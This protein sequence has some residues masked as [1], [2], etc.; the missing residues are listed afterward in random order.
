MTVRHGSG[1]ILTRIRK[2]L[3][4]SI[5]AATAEHRQKF[6]HDDY[7]AANIALGGLRQVAVIGWPETDGLGN[8]EA[9][10]ILEADNG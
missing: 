1:D 2:Q 7:K 10:T 9:A 3:A 4:R 8:D 5:R 6:P